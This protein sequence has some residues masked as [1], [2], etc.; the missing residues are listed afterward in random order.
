MDLSQ[1][2]PDF[3]VYIFSY[4]NRVD[5]NQYLNERQDTIRCCRKQ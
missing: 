4:K 3:Y 5:L 1:N 2:K